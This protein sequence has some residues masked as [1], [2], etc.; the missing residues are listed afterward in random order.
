MARIPPEVWTRNE[1]LDKLVYQELRE[2]HVCDAVPAYEVAR[3]VQDNALWPV[4]KAAWSKDVKA[5]LARLR[6][7]RGIT[8]E[9]TADPRHWAETTYILLSGPPFI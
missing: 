4:G 5:S 6:R 9:V 8:I 3:W 2:H 1:R 7:R